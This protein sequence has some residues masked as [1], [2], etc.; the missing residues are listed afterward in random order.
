MPTE[1]SIRADRSDMIQTV[2]SAEATK[3]DLYQ[4][5]ISCF[6]YPEISG[7]ALELHA[8]S[9]DRASPGRGP[10]LSR[11]RAQACGLSPFQPRFLVAISP[12]SRKADNRPATGAAGVRYRRSGRR[13][14]RQPDLLAEKGAKPDDPGAR[15]RR[16]ESD[17]ACPIRRA[18]HQQWRRQNRLQVQSAKTTT[19][20]SKRLKLHPVH[21]SFFV[22]YRPL[23]T[24]IRRRH[25][26]AIPAVEV[27]C[28]DSGTMMHPRGPDRKS[29]ARSCRNPRSRLQF[30][31]E[32]TNTNQTRF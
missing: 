9:M 21:S 17:R 18:C 24:L 28:F 19:P 14:E 13:G 3:F 16:G 32:L 4:A 26:T 10:L 22:Y 23:Q 30:N 25:V 5:P 29:R 27:P 11:S 1:S 31:P 7:F 20:P 12:A 2:L 15:C 8:K 6:C